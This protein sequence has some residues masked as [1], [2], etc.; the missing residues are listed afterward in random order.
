L[1]RTAAEGARR[2]GAAAV[3]GDK[4]EGV[5]NKGVVLI[6]IEFDLVGRGLV[7]KLLQLFRLLKMK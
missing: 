3:D 1:E 6:V 5:N 4:L 2:R 7:G